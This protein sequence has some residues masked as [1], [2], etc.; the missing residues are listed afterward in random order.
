MMQSFQDMPVLLKNKTLLRMFFAFASFIGGIVAFILF[1]D[2]YMWLPFFG[3]AGICVFLAVKLL[4]DFKHGKIITLEGNCIE[5]LLS[6]TKSKAKTVF[7]LADDK[8]IKVP[9]KEKY[10]SIKQ[11]DYII[12]YINAD[13]SVDVDGSIYHVTD[14]IALQVTS[15]ETQPEK[16]TVVEAFKRLSGNRQS[17]K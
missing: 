10:R 17:K 11:G 13:T 3:V 4:R 15:T 9:I 8:K 1:R 16:E 6:P 5:V 14:Y 12:L 7:F 2:V